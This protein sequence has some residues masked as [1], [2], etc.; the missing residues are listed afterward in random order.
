[1]DLNEIRQR[2][3]RVDDR[4]KELFLE[5]M[6]YAA[7]VAEEK[8]RTGA[9]VYVPKREQEILERRQQDV[10]RR[11][12]P[13]CRAFFGQL[14]GIS[15]TCQY[16][17]LKEG[18]ALLSGL[19][20]GEGEARLTFACG[21]YSGYPAAALNAAALAGLLVTECSAVRDLKGRLR[22]DLRLAGDF[23]KELAQAAV[24]QILKETEQARLLPAAGE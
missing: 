5:R 11:L 7:E 17:R 18:S 24:L 2:I 15:R 22:C 1:M 4:M 13:A 8:K 10:E 12:A 19:C 21:P 9:D 14:M 20:G 3:D 16:A 23:S 6:D